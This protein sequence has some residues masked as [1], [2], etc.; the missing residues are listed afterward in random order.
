MKKFKYILYSIGLL[1]F[2]GCSESFLDTKNLYQK[3]DESYYSTPHD[4][5]EALTGAY[6][7]LGINAGNNNPFIVSD[8]MSD[9]CFGGG[10]QDDVPGFHATDGFTVS[11]PDYYLDLFE[12]NWRGILRVN[13]I[14]K[15]FDQAQYTDQNARNQALGEA[16]F[17][18][19]FF[20]LRLSQFFGPVP[21]KLEP[22]PLNLPR[23]TPEEMYG[24]IAFDLKS[25]IDVMPSTPYGDIPLGRLGHATKWAAEGYLAR[26]F[27]FYT[28]YYNKT[29]I[30]LPDGSTLTKDNVIAYLTDCI[31]NSGHKLLDDF[32]NNWPYSAVDRYSLTSNNNLD[33]EN[34]GDGDVPGNEETIFAIKYSPYGGWSPPATQLSYSNQH[35]LYVGFRGQRF[36]PFGEGWGGGTVNPQLYETFEDGD[37][38]REGSILN[39]NDPIAE[40]AHM[41]SAFVY[42][43]NTAQHETGFWQKKYMPTYD[44]TAAGGIASIFNA[45]YGYNVTDMQLW[46]MQDDIL[47]RFA[48]VLLMAA[49]LGAPNAQNYFDQVRERA[50]LGSKPVTLDNIKIERRCELA[51]EGLRYFDLLRWQD[52]EEAFAVAT[53]IPVRNIG[54]EE[55]YTVT[56]R[57]E[58]GGYLPI[59][60]AEITLSE[61]V[62]EQTPGWD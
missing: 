46:N 28:G 16:H 31:D 4:I 20:Y 52:A 14:L 3:S 48:D 47:L 21:L 29:E 33:Y 62:L 19:A 61:G 37:I 40:D 17:L 43:T 5:E 53:N 2:V 50:G 1:L 18:R 7:C 54:V 59:P 56:F 45:I 44:S 12:T 23:A 51:F 24:Q 42:G 55:N 41:A 32:R 34:G 11:T 30:A 15:R 8:L 36:L 26:V 13:M 38:R 60:D 49:E 6:A 35:V 22:A 57:P 27:L 39:F 58:T 9:D 10:G 25:A